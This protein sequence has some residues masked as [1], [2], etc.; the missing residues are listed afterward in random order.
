VDTPFE[1]V[2]ASV[3]H[4]AFHK[5]HPYADKQATKSYVITTVWLTEEAAA[6]T[7]YCDCSEEERAKWKVDEQERRENCGHVRANG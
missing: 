1:G 3:D 2:V 5:D 6:P 7:L 4:E